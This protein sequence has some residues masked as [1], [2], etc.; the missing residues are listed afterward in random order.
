VDH[1]AP[2]DRWPRM[3]SGR[4]APGRD[5]PAHDRI[6]DA[7]AEA[8]DGAGYA[9]LTV[10]RI[11]DAAC[12]SRATF[13]QY[14]RDVD[15]CFRSAYRHHAARLTEHVARHVADE[16]S[17]LAVL[18]ALAGFAA[19]H[20][21]STRLLTREGLAAGPA[22]LVERE[23]LIARVELAM[24][25]APLSIDLPRAILIGGALRFLAVRLSGGPGA[26]GLA[27]ELREWAAAFARV[28]GGRSVSE[29]LTPR[30]PQPDPPAP[31]QGVRPNGSARERIL[32]GTALAIRAKGYPAITVADIVTAA[33]TSRRR[34]YNEFRCKADA[35]IAA[36][37]HGFQ[38]VMAAGAPAFFSPGTW[39]ERVWHG[40][41]AFTAF[42]AREP[43]IAHL[44]FIECYAIGPQYT[45]RVHDTQLAFTLF[46][47]EGY[48][49][50]PE[51]EAVSRTQSTLA[52][53]SIF[54][55]A[56]QASRRGPRFDLRRC[57]P[58]AVY[59]AL[60]PFIGVE[61]AAEFVR[62]K[63]AAQQSRVTEAA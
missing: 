57:Q 37:E 38:Q 5:R 20:P 63:L 1:L 12:V 49:Q 60:A 53:A 19:E 23:S 45:L 3:S 61:E 62:G 56:F 40:A 2:S 55:L 42:M 43:L 4:G 58:L 25:D 51:A 22:G 48:R 41:T 59:M 6:L 33:G 31:I 26:E 50:R 11:L 30:L 8:V 39:R 32:R 18:E 28:P 27:G 52:A 14:F 16:P 13:Y 36:Y 46:L 15:D 7:V 21:S 44:G 24:R 54:E 17:E 35:Y 10:Q 29:Q 47:E 9:H 34:F